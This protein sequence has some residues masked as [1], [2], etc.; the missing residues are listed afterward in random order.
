M[1]VNWQTNN[2]SCIISKS[3]FGVFMN[4]KTSVVFSILIIFI[5]ALGIFYFAIN[6]AGDYQKAAPVADAQFRSFLA[7]MNYEISNEPYL[8]P[9]YL[10]KL[11][12]I[13]QKNEYIAAVTIKSDRN[14]YFAY[15]LSSKYISASSASPEI[16]VTSPA[17][18]VRSTDIP[19]NDTTNTEVQAAVYLL[20]PSS[21]FNYA[22]YS[23]CI[24]AAGTFIS[25]ILLFFA[26]RPGRV[27]SAAP[28]TTYANDTVN[29]AEKSG[30]QADYSMPQRIQPKSV[31]PKDEVKTIDPI[32]LFSPATGLSWESYLETRLDAEL[33][34][35]ASSEQE[36]SLIQIRTVNIPHNHPCAK[37]IASVLIDT[38]KYRDL[39]FEFGDD[40]YICVLPSVDLNKTLSISERLYQD[41]KQVIASFNLSNQLVIGISTRTMRLVQGIRLV[42]ESIEAVSKALEEPEL[43]IV[44]FRV[45]A[46]RYKQFLTEE[47]KK[48][49]VSNY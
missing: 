36:L 38:F 2:E 4:N 29:I 40:S 14:T 11:R 33:T 12:E 3:P 42:K 27:K 18:I 21:I 19:Y 30:T 28:T 41:L 23:F 45:N 6:I 20:K 24:I 10:E 15:P 31:K 32:G 35:A 37:E 44:A 26:K 8:S 49:N 16:F 25:L 47:L 48:T 9:A 7:D 17:L 46:E 34:R 43:P 13:I 22:F 39:L 5:F 1:P